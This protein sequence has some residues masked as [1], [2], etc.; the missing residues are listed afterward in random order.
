M[1]EYRE[2][3][4]KEFTDIKKERDEM[5]KKI[6]DDIDQAVSNYGK[7]NKYDFIINGNSVLYGTKTNDLTSNIIKIINKNYK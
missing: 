6:V 5:M 7:E 2:M 1:Q 3:R 4:Q